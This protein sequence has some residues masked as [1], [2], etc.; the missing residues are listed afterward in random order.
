MQFH[1]PVLSGI[2]IEERG[3]ASLDQRKEDELVAPIGQG[4]FEGRRWSVDSIPRSDRW[5]ERPTA[6]LLP[7][8]RIAENN[9]A[10][11]DSLAGYEQYRQFQVETQCI[12]HISA[13][14]GQL[15]NAYGDLWP[16]QPGNSDEHAQEFLST[17][18]LLW[19]GRSGDV[20]QRRVRRS[21]WRDGT[22]SLDFHQVNAQNIPV[23]GGRIVLTYDS[24]Q[25]LAIVNSS[26]FPMTTEELPR[27]DDAPPD[28]EGLELAV[29][30][31]LKT[32]DARIQF[33]PWL[34]CSSLKAMSSALLRRAAPTS[35]GCCHSFG[36][37]TGAN[38]W[39]HFELS[40]WMRSSSIGR[41]G[42][43]QACVLAFSRTAGIAQRDS[44]RCLSAPTRRHRR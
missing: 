36:S 8:S 27:F 1:F 6:E 16:G 34:M 18:Q 33:E 3:Y 7:F 2:S 22:V 9:S 39:R 13:F 17:Y 5:V 23:L 29:R 15:A 31:Y 11:E 42:S 32:M 26:L 4:L 25:R 14:T 24:D 21:T 19:A 43:T 40:F 38:T 41:C 35:Y 30:D 12:N 10:T 37:R 44:L 20:G 28:Q